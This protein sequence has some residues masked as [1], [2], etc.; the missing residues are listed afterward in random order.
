MSSSSKLATGKVKG[1]PRWIWVVAA[2]LAILGVLKLRQDAQSSSATSASSSVPFT[3]SVT[4]HGGV[5]NASTS[6]PTPSA[7]VVAPPV[8]VRRI[9]PDANVTTMGP[10]VPV[11]GALSW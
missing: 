1:V 7:E 11:A 8:Y 4:T 5:L 9:V 10:R 3:S 6:V 2:G